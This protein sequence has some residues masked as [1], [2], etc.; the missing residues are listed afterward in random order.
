MF[1][2]I[3]LGMLIAIV[4]LAIALMIS[5]DFFYDLG[6]KIT[7]FIAIT[8]SMLSIIFGGIIGKQSATYFYETQ[9]K[10]Y[11]INKETIESSICNENLN[12]LEKI[13]LVEQATILNEK[14]ITMK[15]DV[16]KWWYWYLDDNMVKD[17]E[18][19]DLSICN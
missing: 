2:G 11:Y 18:P 9:V 4:I 5:D 16:T 19:V 10:T 1:L 14:I 6:E 7:W 12:G 13:Q 15:V 17:L 8:L 3:F